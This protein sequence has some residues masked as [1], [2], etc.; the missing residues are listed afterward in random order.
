M[1]LF[2]VFKKKNV[3]NNMFN[4]FLAFFRV[5]KEVAKNEDVYGTFLSELGGKQFGNGLF[6]TFSVAEVNKWTEIT[7]EAYQGLKGQIKPFG[8]DWLGRIFAIDLREHR[9]G[10]I[11]MLEIGTGQALEIPCNMEVF[12]NEEITLSTDACLAYSFYQEWCSSGNTIPKLGQCVGYK[13]PLF[14]GG[15]DDTTNLEISDLEVYWG[16][17]AQIMN[18]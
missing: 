6:N 18:T 16:I 12:L 4:D 11:L 17:L 10:L 13:V 5:D 7:E 9:N 14:L 15:K 3:E 8:Y 2:D 1:G